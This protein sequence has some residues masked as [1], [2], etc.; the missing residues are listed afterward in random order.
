MSRSPLLADVLRRTDIWRGDAS[1][2]TGGGGESVTSGHPLLDAELPG[3]GWP[4]GAL[5]ELLVE[6]D[7]CGELPLLLPALQHV[8]RHDG[9]LALVAPPYPPYAPAWL[10]AGMDLRHLL[11]VRAERREAA[12]SC[13]QILASGAF[14]AVLAWL[15][16]ADAGILRRLNLATGQHQSLAFV[17][18][19]AACARQASPAPL[20]VQVAN[21][22]EHVGVR[23]I[24][25]RGRP[26]THPVYLPLINPVSRQPVPGDLSHA[27]T[28]GRLSELAGSLR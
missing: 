18:R 7:A 14:E 3:G 24:K 20:R 2:C 17:F 22:A 15:P 21:Q 5:T 4:R 11:I 19:P 8:M 16:H 25:R 23:L 28:E 6:R 26:H 10:T 27:R 1:P 9:W 12:W 13:E